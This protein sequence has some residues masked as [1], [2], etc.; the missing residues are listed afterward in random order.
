MEAGRREAHAG[1]E[2]R[3]RHE[4]IASR[5]AR[6]DSLCLSLAGAYKQTNRNSASD[7]GRLDGSEQGLQTI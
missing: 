4:R 6:P 7:I 1:D 2:H 5:V 3:D